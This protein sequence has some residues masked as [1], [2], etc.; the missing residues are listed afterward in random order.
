MFLEREVDH[1][2]RIRRTATAPR[3]DEVAMIHLAR[4]GYE[5]LA[6]QNGFDIAWSTVG[7]ERC[8]PGFTAAEANL[9]SNGEAVGYVYI[10]EYRLSGAR[11][12]GRSGLMDDINRFRIRGSGELASVLGSYWDPES[13]GDSASIVCL[14]RVWLHPAAAKG[15]KWVASAP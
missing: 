3:K 5:F 9:M 7:D 12:A 1:S 14:D 6:V 4:G 13:F 8:G 10:L 11:S 15:S 2:G